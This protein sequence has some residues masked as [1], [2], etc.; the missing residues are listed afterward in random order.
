L[1]PLNN[2][3][4]I[5]TT[6]VRQHHFFDVRHSYALAI[7]THIELEIEFWCIKIKI[8]GREFYY[9]RLLMNRY[10]RDVVEWQN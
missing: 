6:G 7:A 8:L 4:R 9:N 2:Y 3:R 10:R 1:K 5:Q